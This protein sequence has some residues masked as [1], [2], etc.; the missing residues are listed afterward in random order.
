MRKRTILVALSI[1]LDHCVWTFVWCLSVFT[2][3]GRFPCC[4][5]PSP[6]LWVQT[7]DWKAYSVDA[8]HTH[9]IGWR[10]NWDRSWDCTRRIR[11]SS[12]GRLKITSADRSRMIPRRA[13]YACPQVVL[14]FQSALWSSWSNFRHQKRRRQLVCQCCPREVCSFHM[15]VW[16]MLTTILSISLHLLTFPFVTELMDRPSSTYGVI[17]VRRKIGFSHVSCDLSECRILILKSFLI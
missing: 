17:S 6:L 5:P 12:I 2:W 7:R 14:K 15:H 10:G 4:P 13:P 16:I 9:S 3:Q 8:T 11:Q 1:Y